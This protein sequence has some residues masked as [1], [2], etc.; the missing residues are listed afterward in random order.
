MKQRMKDFRQWGKEHKGLLAVAGISITVLVALV[1]CAR[2]KD[3]I[4]HILS[5]LK[6]AV[7]NAP[8]EDVVGSVS[9]DLSDAT[10]PCWKCT[11][12]KRILLPNRFP[13]LSEGCPIIGITRLRRRK[14]QNALESS[15]QSMKR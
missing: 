13:S 3:E 15:W 6:K 11:I 9:I 12:P 7:K 5:L 1:L 8:D 14:K 10:Q 2:N 4:D